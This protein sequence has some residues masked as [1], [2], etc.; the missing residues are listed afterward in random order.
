LN[1]FSALTR[2]KL[3]KIQSTLDRP[4]NRSMGFMTVVIYPRAEWDCSK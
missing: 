1:P 3:R 2:G 4:L